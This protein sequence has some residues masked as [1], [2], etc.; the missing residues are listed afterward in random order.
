LDKYYETPNYINPRYNVTT[1]KNFINN[2]LPWQDFDKNTLDLQYAT[3]YDCPLAGGIDL[4]IDG[5]NFGSRARVYIDQNECLV[6]SFSRSLN[7]RVETIKCTLPRG[8]SPGEK[9]LRVENG[10]LPGLFQETHNSFSY[11]MAPPIPDRPIVTNIGAYKV[12][13]VWTPPGN[14]FDNMVVTG[15]KIL[16]FRPQ[17][18]SRISNITVGNVTTTSIRGALL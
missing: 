10:I 3:T 2:H 14:E 9:R 4:Q 16:W 6:T 18:P 8:N 7:G 11:R 15:Y 1:R 12:D 17:Y 13:L 5:I